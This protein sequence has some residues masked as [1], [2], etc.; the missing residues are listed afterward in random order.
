[1]TL[2][3]FTNP[4]IR[5]ST[6]AEN[7]DK[8]SFP[9]AAEYCLATATE[10]GK[11]VVRM[12]ISESSWKSNCL[13]V[14]ADTIVEI[15]GR[16]L[17]K[18]ATAEEAAQMLRMLSGSVHTVHTGVAIFSGRVLG[19]SSSGS[20]TMNTF[21][22]ST[23]VTFQSLG[24]EDIAAYIATGEPFDKAGGYGIQGVGGQMVEH[25]AGCYF[26]VMGLPVRSLSS[27]IARMHAQGL[28]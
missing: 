1:M 4:V 16:I 23:S 6:F 27:H 19:S 11:D 7:L 26:N 5:V 14:S 28:V 17:E 10:K 25:I 15:D 18:P 22:E 2:M 13:L 12:L 8:K 20:F 21:I 9:S 3:G 24:E